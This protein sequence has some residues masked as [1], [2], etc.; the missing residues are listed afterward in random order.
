MQIHMN[1]LANLIS[2]FMILSGIALQFASN[3]EKKIDAWNYP[4]RIKKLFKSR[5][6]QLIIGFG[7]IYWGI[8]LMQF[9]F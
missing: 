9:S 6:I 7:L 3:F 5:F 4:E 1:S 2:C 8:E